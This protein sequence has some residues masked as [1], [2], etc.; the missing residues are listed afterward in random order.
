MGEA[1]DH[2]RLGLRRVTHGNYL[3]FYEPRE[4]G[5]LLVRVLHGTRKFEDLFRS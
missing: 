3:I 4:S 1:V 2:I 5:I